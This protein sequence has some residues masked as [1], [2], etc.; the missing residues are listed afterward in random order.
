MNGGVYEPLAV[1]IAR[2]YP[3]T[4]VQ[5][6]ALSQ[7]GSL[8]GFGAQ[9]LP[10]APSAASKRQPES[11]T[12]WIHMSNAMMVTALMKTIRTFCELYEQEVPYIPVTR[13]ECEPSK[14]LVCSSS[15]IPMRSR[16]VYHF[17]MTAGG[18][19]DESPKGSY[20]LPWRF[21]QSTLCI[22]HVLMCLPDTKPKPQWAY[23]TV[24]L[25]IR[26]P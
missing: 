9:K 12:N 24:C 6:N 16:A 14:Y 1:P 2:S 11:A 5:Y 10:G 25:G 20:R 26:T 13:A 23:T 19:D 7:V 3:I 18:I 17:H 8:R 15:P 22:S 4:T 21:S